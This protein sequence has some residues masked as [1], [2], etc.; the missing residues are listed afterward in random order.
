MASQP[1]NTQITVARTVRT[2]VQT[3][4]NASIKEVA[5]RFGDR[6]VIAPGEEIDT[7]NVIDTGGVVAPG[8]NPA[9]RYGMPLVVE[10]R[11]RATTTD[12]LSGVT[13]LD[14]PVQIVG[15]R[16][17]LFIQK[18]AGHLTEDL[19]QDVRDVAPV[20]RGLFRAV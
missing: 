19:H 3:R 16:H 7:Y 1:A 17:D 6:E 20:P 5:Q 10:S 13:G 11:T 8:P 18:A 2:R 9:W 12:V 15:T 4:R 14:F